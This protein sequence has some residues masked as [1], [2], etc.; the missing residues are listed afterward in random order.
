MSLIFT[1]GQYAVK[2]YETQTDS[3]GSPLR[4][5]GP[6]STVTVPGALRSAGVPQQFFLDPA[7]WPTADVRP[8]MQNTYVTITG[9]D[10]DG[11]T[12]TWFITDTNLRKG[13]DDDLADLDYIEVNATLKE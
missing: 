13:F 11:V 1:T 4:S 10:R 6:T 5:D 3:F 8:G 12:R 9:P 2:R 7:A